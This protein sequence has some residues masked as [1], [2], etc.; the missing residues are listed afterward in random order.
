MKRSERMQTVERVVSDVERKRAEALA[1][2]EKRVA[3]SE[4]K[5]T[6]LEGYQKSYADQFTA[7]AKSGMGA[8]GLRDYQ[9]FMA[10]LA[11][12]VRQQ[13]LVV[14]KTRADRDAVLKT[15]QTAAQRA[16]AVGGLVKRW[17]GDEQRVADRQEQLES[18][19]RAQRPSPQSLRVRGH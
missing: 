12:A 19:E 1:L 9:T 11:D 7:R 15:W 18:D 3:E 14:A 8:N 10:R 16:E 4:A 2:S 5:L 17:Q 13:V 6:E